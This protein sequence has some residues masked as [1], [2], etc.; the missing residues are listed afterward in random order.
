MP[1]TLKPNAQHFPT[2]HPYTL[3]PETLMPMPDTFPPPTR[4]PYTLLN[5][6]IPASSPVA[7]S[8]TPLPPSPPPQKTCPLRYRPLVEKLF[9]TYE[10]FFPLSHLLFRPGPQLFTRLS[11]VFMQRDLEKAHRVGIHVSHHDSTLGYGGG[12]AHVSH[13]DSPV[14]HRG[15]GVLPST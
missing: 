9:P 3:K 11:T 6:K 7:R 10:V 5:P 13:H 14:G 4:K 15:A 8:T 1:Y 2:S 12:G